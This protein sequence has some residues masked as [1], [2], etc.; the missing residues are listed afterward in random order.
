MT[1]TFKTNSDPIQQTNET[2]NTAHQ[3]LD[4]QAQH[5]SLSDSVR[6]QSALLAEHQG[7]LK[8]VFPAISSVQSS[9]GAWLTVVGVVASI[10]FGLAIFNLT[11]TNAVGDR[12]DTISTGV[13]TRLGGLETR[14]GA[15][16]AQLSVLPQ[17]VAHE[18]RQQEL[19]TPPRR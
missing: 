12:L 7:N 14:T 2:F 13:N 19:D 5:E 17:K 16:E 10:L 8:G 11:R 9:L 3:L 1:G 15:M 6:R 4:L 18:L